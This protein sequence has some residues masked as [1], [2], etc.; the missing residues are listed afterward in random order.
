MYHTSRMGTP[1]I[2]SSLLL[3]YLSL[4]WGVTVERAKATLKTS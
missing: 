2:V 1:L 4:L 3:L